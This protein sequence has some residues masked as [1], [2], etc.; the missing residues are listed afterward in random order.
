VLVIVFA[1]PLATHIPLATLA[2]ILFVVAWNLSE[3]HRVM[4]MLRRAPRADVVILLV[5]LFLTVFV[6][7][8]VAVNI[9]VILATLHFLRR[10]A[11]SVEVTALPEEDLP[12]NQTG[13]VTTLPKDVMIFRI[14]G[15]F[16]FAA[17]ESF[18]RALTFTNNQPRVVILSLRRV[19][20]VD[21]T[22]IGKLEHVMHDLQKRHIR[23]I[24]AEANALV[25]EKLERAGLIDL[26]GREQVFTGLSAAIVSASI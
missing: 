13:E 8:V 17:A 6:D 4:S 19:P 23:V 12:L 10:M 16:F 5:T 3:M 26:A 21:M 9:G 18:E 14:D 22:A 20:F 25:T 11:A 24:L 1:A 7:L 2:A 15:P